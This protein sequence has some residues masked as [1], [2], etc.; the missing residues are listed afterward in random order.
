MKKENRKIL[1]VLVVILLGAVCTVGADTLLGLH[2]MNTWG[3][4]SIL[5]KVVYM[6]WGGILAKVGA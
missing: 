5:H 6:L 2:S 4:A 1:L 3:L